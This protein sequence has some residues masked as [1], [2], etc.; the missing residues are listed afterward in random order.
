MSEKTILVVDDS[1][2]VRAM[3][4]MALKASG[5]RVVSLENWEALDREIKS[6]KPDLILMDIKM[7]EMTGDFALGFFR[8]ER[9]LEDVYILLYSDIEEGEIAKRASACRADGYIAKSWGI[10][11]M[12]ETVLH[13]LNLPPTRGFAKSSD[14][15]MEECQT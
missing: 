4:S 10:E 15:E 2:L 12:M 8:E 9:G 6:I 3:S 5:Y 14:I 13:F 11:R 1:K 7:P